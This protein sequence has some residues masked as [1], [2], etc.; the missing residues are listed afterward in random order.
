M[1]FNKG[2][3]ADPDTPLMTFKKKG[4]CFMEILAIVTGIVIM[5]AAVVSN[6]M[7]MK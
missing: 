4:D 7:M 3:W 2:V 1:S 6:F 5:I